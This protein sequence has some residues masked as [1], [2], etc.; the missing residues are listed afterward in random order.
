VSALREA[1][2][3]ASHP[4]CLGLADRLGIPEVPGTWREF[5]TWTTD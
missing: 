1:E 5:E 3:T 2:R 4:L